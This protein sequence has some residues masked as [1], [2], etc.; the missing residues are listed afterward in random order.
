MKLITDKITPNIGPE[1][2]PVEFLVLHYTACDI[3]KTL[4]I[5]L[6]REMKVSSQ[7][8]IDFNGDCYDLGNFY[9]GPIRRGAHAGVSKI[10]CEGKEFTGLNANSIG[11]EI[12]NVN[13]N[14]FPYTEEQYSTLKELVS[15]L[16]ARFPALSSA[17]R[18]I[19]HEHIAGFRGKCDPGLKFDWKRFFNSLN[20]EPENV[21]S[22]FVCTD[23]DTK[24]IN[25]EIAGNFDR[26]P[27]FW[28][29]L[30]SALESRIGA[31]N[32]T[33]LL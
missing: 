16:Q 29:S 12:V 25:N 17:S 14:I 24:F 27:Q 10:S 4:E 13:G 6:S 32:Q 19:G 23:S 9:H 1:E 11:I 20:M 22:Q 18:I 8:V 15:H 7:F 31:R 2:I 33:S 28:T 3:N 21:H 5:F 30:S 26:K